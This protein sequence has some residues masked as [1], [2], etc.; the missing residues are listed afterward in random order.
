MSP[1]KLRV[2]LVSADDETRTQLAG[3]L[4]GAGFD[5]HACSELAMPSAFQA[6]VVISA[7]NLSGE[8]LVRDI[9]SWIRSTRNQRVVV[10]TSKP[11]ALNDLVVAHGE[12]LFVLPAPVFGW[13][14][15]DTLRTTAPTKPRGA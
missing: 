11:S 8:A 9:R 13:D 10:V 3:Y 12:R 4:K 2:A 6:L 7:R 5:V 15:V 14:L 1:I